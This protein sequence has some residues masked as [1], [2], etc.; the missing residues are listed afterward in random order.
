LFQ[1]DIDNHEITYDS[2]MKRHSTP[3]PPLL[4]GEGENFPVIL[5]FSGVP[6]PWLT[7][8]PAS[9]SIATYAGITAT[10]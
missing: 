7:A 8:V 2:A 5:P 3:I 6:A 4:K 10:R 9:L 1:V